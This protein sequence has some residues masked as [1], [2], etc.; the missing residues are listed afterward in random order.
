[1]SRAF[2]FLFIFYSDIIKGKGEQR[3]YLFFVKLHAHFC[4][5]IIN[6][7]VCKDKPPWETNLFT[8]WRI[9]SHFFYGKPEWK[10]KVPLFI[11]KDKKAPGGKTADSVVYVIPRPSA[12]N[13]GCQIQ[14]AIMY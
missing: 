8:E 12:A 4:K 1:M 9:D 2:V 11:S 10:L 3:S 7:T 5:A 13:G 6:E 14:F